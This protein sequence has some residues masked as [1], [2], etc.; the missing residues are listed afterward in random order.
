M[1]ERYSNMNLIDFELN[2]TA[3]C[4]RLFCDHLKALGFKQILFVYTAIKLTLLCKTR[5][6]LS[7]L[8]VYLET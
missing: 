1:I 3:H 4:A 5:I 7:I 8:N 6:V 2:F